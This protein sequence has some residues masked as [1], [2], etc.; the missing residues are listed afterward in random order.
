MKPAMTSRRP[1][2]ACQPKTACPL[3]ACL[4]ILGTAWTPEILW[5]LRDR[6][7]RF[8]ELKRD[9]SRVSAKMLTARLKILTVQGVVTRTVSP[10]S[11]PT[12]TYALTPLGRK[13]HPAI[14]AI[15]AVGRALRHPRGPMRGVT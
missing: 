7:R 13:F 6:P 4:E 3:D 11:P 15:A 2:P 10:A 8:G 5:Y 9:L 12:V 14:R 1:P